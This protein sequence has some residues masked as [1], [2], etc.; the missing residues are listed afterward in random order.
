[1]GHPALLAAIGERGVRAAPAPVVLVRGRSLASA[2]DRLAVE[3]PLEIRV[4][5]GSEERGL[6]ITMRTPGEDGELAAGFLFTEGLV[7]E[8]AEL[9]EIVEGESTVVVELRGRPLP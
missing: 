1:R 3:A 4:R 9:G 5:A 6:S 2:E 7:R 8:R